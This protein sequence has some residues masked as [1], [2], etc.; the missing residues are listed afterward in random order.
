MSSIRPLVTI[1]ILVVAGAYLYVKINEGSLQ[2]KTE[3]SAAWEQTPEGVPPLATAT[4]APIAGD[5]AAPPWNASAAPAV[6]EVGTAP[7]A[8]T[9]AEPAAPTTTA[10]ATAPA[11]PAMPE[12]PELT[13][14]SIPDAT[15]IAQTPTA[16]EPSV[17]LPAE[18]PANIPEARYP[19]AIGTSPAVEGIGVPAVAAPP[20][21]STPVGASELPPGTP[22]PATATTPEEMNQATI[23]AG[24]TTPP[25]PLASQPNP[26]RQSAPP[27][28][29]AGRYGAQAATTPIESTFA[30]SW[31]G[32]QAMLERGELTQA[33]EQLSRWYGDPSLTPTDTERVESLLSQLAGTVV[34]STE[35]RLAPAHVVKQ[36]ESLET[37]AKEYNVPWQL[38]A[39][40]N[41]VA[42]PDQ[43]RPGQELKVV[44]GPFAA[45]V[46]LGRNQLTLTI[47]GRYAGKF[48]VS[49]MPG[50]VADGEWVVDQKLGA[51]TSAERSIVLR[52][53][54]AAAGAPGSAP[55]VLTIT[56]ASPA[57]VSPT[58][59]TTIQVAAKDAEELSD[60]LSIGSRVVV[61][62]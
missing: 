42:T 20:I 16:I 19:D 36:G 54:P 41:G 7:A 22:T 35:H 5:S 12:M 18:L 33:H 58:G 17:P 34:Y 37:I 26:L 25:A 27:T 61:R 3:S 49:A 8:T 28:A 39:K 1:T 48:P 59:G 60:I 31:P 55:Q 6:P 4:V 29:D 14:S 40:I 9:P 38:L 32:I 45:L 13:T 15:A 43:V 62:K 46:D 23:E 53:G 47:D 11:M 21:V 24:P 57:T 51:P 56:A 30:E 2:P 44:R 10:Q 52:G 50:T